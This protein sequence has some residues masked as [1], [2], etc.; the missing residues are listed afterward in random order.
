MTEAHNTILDNR[1]IRVEQAKVNRTLFI[2]KFQRNTSD[3]LLKEILERHGPVEELTILQN[4]ATGKPKGCGFVKYKY[5][6]DAIRAYLVH[7]P[8]HQHSDSNFTL[9]RTSVKILNGF[10]NGHPTL[11]RAL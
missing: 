2:A 7:T 1:H 8:C 11:T 3:R 10:A 4:Y 9:H 5:R 6:E